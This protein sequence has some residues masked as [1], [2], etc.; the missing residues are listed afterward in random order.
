MKPEH[1]S[2]FS[3]FSLRCP[4]HAAEK[5]ISLFVLNF[6]GPFPIGRMRS[7]IRIGIDLRRTFPT[8]KYNLDYHDHAKLN[9]K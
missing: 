5:L 9:L 8:K 3:L 7:P 1:Y 2:V 4:F 6:N